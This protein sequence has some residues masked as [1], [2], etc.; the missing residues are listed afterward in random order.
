MERLDREEAEAQ[1]PR[2]GS[3]VPPAAAVR[4]LRGLAKTW[5]L[6][7]RGTGRK[8][9]ADALFEVVDVLGFREMTLR[10]TPDAVAHGFHE[11]IPE[12]LDLTVGY[13]RGE[14]I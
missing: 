10:L 13:G 7:D 3:G 14:R 11:V 1:A 8:M 12:R 4:Y 6:A 2:E 5:R 9:L